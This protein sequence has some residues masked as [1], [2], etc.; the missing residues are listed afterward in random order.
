MPLLL[1]AQL[2]LAADITVLS[3][4]FDAYTTSSFSGT[5]SWVTGYASDPW[6]TAT[7]GGVYAKTDD[8]TGTWGSGGAVDNHL[9]YTG[10]SWDDSTFYATLYQADDD[11]IGLVFRYTDA[12]NFYLLFFPGGNFGP[13]TGTGAITYPLSGTMLYKVVAGSATLVAKSSTSLTLRSSVDVMIVT[14]GTNIDAYVDNDLSGT[15]SAGEHLI[16]TTDSAFSAGEIGLYCLNDGERAAG[17][18]FDDVI[19]TQPD[20]DSDGITDSEDNCASTSNSTQTDSDGD[21]T[22]DACDSDADGDGYTS[23]TSGGIDCDDTNSAINPYVAELCSTTTDDNCSGSTNDIGATGCVNYYYDGDRDGY[24]GSTTAC[25]CT[26]TGRYD[27]TNDDDCDDSDASDNPAGIETC[28][29]DD[30]DCDGSIDESATDEL[31]WYADADG[32]GYGDA[33]DS[34]LSC[35]APIDYVADDTDCDDAEA[36]VYPGAPESCDSV[37]EDC[38]G[39]TDEDAVDAE[40]T[41]ADEDGDTYG[42][43]SAVTTDCSIPA[44]NVFDNTDCDDTDAAIYPSANEV[45]D[46]VDQDCN[47]LVDDSAIDAAAWYADDDGDTWGDASDVEYDCDPVAGRTD[48]PG[49]CADANARINPGAT[50]M[51]NA[52]DDDCDGVVDDNASDATTYYADLDGDGHGDP[53]APVL[54]CTQPA[55]SSEDTLDC[56]DARSDV[57]EGAPELPDTLDNNCDGFADEGIDT[58]GDG[59]DDYTERTDWGSD[60]YERDTD[61]DG[62]EDGDEVSRG[63]SPVLVDSDGG[64]VGDGAEVLQDGT[65]PLNPGDDVQLD[66]DGDG[67]TDSEEAVLGTDPENADTDGGGTED[68][69]EVADGTDPLDPSDDLPDTGGG[70]APRGGGLYGGCGAAAPVWGLGLVALALRTRRSR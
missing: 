15:Y 62:L 18:Y 70:N 51:C 60:P 61:G 34:T 43:P 49:D 36:G 63:T 22:G 13:N 68:G 52:V 47:A 16:D 5:A 50:E 17:C 44:S 9:V 20:A 30:E 24:G 21:G 40:T 14:S 67:L 57:Y 11:T 48:A 32:D 41:Y 56:D 7:Y 54:G 69:A 27:S 10:D 46:G 26:S 38:D 12:S 28:N 42:D 8:D 65:D 25:I 3:E 23:T 31:T 4:N 53:D 35:S 45:C 37:D 33:S 64:G 6:S 66:T 39:A 2:A 1:L 59:L 19:V 58:D 55:G 29:G